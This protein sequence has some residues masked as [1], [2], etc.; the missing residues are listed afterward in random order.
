MYNTEK[1]KTIIFIGGTSRSGSTLLDLILGNNDKSMSLG[2]IS[3][4]YHPTK[5]KHFA[6]IKELNDSDSVW[7]SIINDKKKHLYDNI[8]EA[9]P[10]IDIFI[11]S[12]KDPLWINYFNRKL[13]GRYDVRNV[14][15]YKKP[16]E[17]A[18]SF[19]KRGYGN[20]WLKTFIHYHRKYNTLINDYFTVYLGDLLKRE[21]VLVELCRTLG[22]SYHE[23]MRNYYGNNKT[24]FYGSETPK[25]KKELD[26]NPKENVDSIIS[27]STSKKINE[28]YTLLKAK[29]LLTSKTG[30][31]DEYF[32]YNKLYILSLKIKRYFNYLLNYIKFKL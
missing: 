20:R 17:L 8:I 15:I 1:R 32:T 27:G 21:D 26:A 16:E 24:I 30:K 5:K 31:R 9:F 13:R 14:L 18:N 3:S 7:G 23:N 29:N 11:D 28:T 2:E 19:M 4:V 25:K 12:S 10:D 22:V 6:L